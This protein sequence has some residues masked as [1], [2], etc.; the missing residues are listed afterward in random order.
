MTHSSSLVT[1]QAWRVAR[2]TN[3]SPAQGRDAF[4]Y[5]E[6][7]LAVDDVPVVDRRGLFVTG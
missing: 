7:D 2:W 6:L 4:V 1:R 5:L 3:V